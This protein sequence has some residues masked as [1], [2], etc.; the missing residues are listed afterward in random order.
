M[1]SPNLTAYSI[2]AAGVAGWACWIGTAVVWC[3]R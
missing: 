1:R 2:A 3:L